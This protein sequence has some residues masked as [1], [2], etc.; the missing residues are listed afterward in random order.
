MVADADQ[1]GSYQT[2]VGDPRITRVGHFIRKTSL[3]ELPQLLNVLIGDMSLV[4]PRPDVPNQK[5]NY[6]EQD[7][8]KRV[9]VKPGIT[10]LAQATLRSAA[11]AKKRT[12]LDFEY[13]D[14]M[15]LW[16][17]IKILFLTVNQLLTKGSH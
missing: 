10:G 17:D 3:D 16:L 9:G 4:G 5:K 2:P 12:A 7:W 14:N 8:N 6:S 15:S 1:V 13:I 11:T